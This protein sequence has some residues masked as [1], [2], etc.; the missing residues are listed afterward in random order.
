MGALAAIALQLIVIAAY[1]AAFE[2][3]QEKEKETETDDE[4]QST[5]E[6]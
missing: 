1:D 4:Q 5:R 6:V 2:S 3:L